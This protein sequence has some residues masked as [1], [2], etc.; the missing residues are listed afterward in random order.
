M[1]ATNSSTMPVSTIPTFEDY[2]R[3]KEKIDAYLANIKNTEIKTDINTAPINTTPATNPVATDKE[4]LMQKYR[5]NLMAKIMKSEG[6]LNEATKAYD[7]SQESLMQKYRDNLMAKIMKSEE[8][9]NEATKAYDESQKAGGGWGGGLAKG[10]GVFADTMAGMAGQKGGYTQGV[11]GE[12]KEQK[13]AG[14]DKYKAALGQE[15][16]YLDNLEKMID[17]YMK[18]AEFKNSEAWR[19]MNYNQRE[20][21]I[22]AGKQEKSEAIK[23]AEIKESKLSPTETLKVA[24]GKAIPDTLD[25]IQKTLD[26]NPELFAS[27]TFKPW[28]ETSAFARKQYGADEQKVESK[29]KSASQQFGRY[30]EGGVLRK[31]D[32]VKYREMFPGLQDTPDVANA[33]LKNIREMMVRKQQTD[34]DALKAQGKNTAGLEFEPKASTGGSPWKKYGGK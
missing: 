14:A 1:D 20:R 17:Q 21:A 11:V 24:E 29:L 33:K 6:T 4:S 7:E 30:M 32:E 12:Y 15:Q 28:A 10:L 16:S 23:R 8:T 27:T 25:D 22:N 31:E 5:D 19:K 2:I 26:E 13:K 34:L 3:E 18:G 9:L